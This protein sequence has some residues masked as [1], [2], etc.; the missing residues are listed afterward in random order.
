VADVLDFHFQLAFHQSLVQL[1]MAQLK[2]RPRCLSFS[3][4]Q[5]G[6]ILVLCVPAKEG[7]AVPAFVELVYALFNRAFNLIYCTTK[8][9]RDITQVC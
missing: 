3:V 9:I 2:I 4:R 7:S 6:L 1:M 5:K 8:T